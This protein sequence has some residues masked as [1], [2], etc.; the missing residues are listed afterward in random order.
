[1]SAISLKQRLNPAWLLWP[2]CLWL[3]IFIILPLCILIV[4]SFSKRGTYGELELAF[5]FGNYAKLLQPVYLRIGIRSLYIA[6]LS[7]LLCLI[8]A[9]PISLIVAFSKPRIQK[10]LLIA[11][12][13]PMWTNLLIRCYAWVYLLRSEGLLNSGLQMLGFIREPLPLIYNSFA[14]ILGLLYNFLP[15]AILPMYASIEKIDRRLFEAARDLGAGNWI[16]FKKI[17][18][19]LSL[20]G[21]SAAVLLVFVPSMSLYIIPDILGGGKTMLLGNLIQNQF[22]SARDWG[23]GS[24]LSVVILLLILVIWLLAM[25]V[26]G[27]KKLEELFS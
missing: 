7:T 3:G 1:M 5:Q 13:L 24:A 16:I 15:F 17:L 19:P 2:L 25:K 21:I 18:L 4:Y 6:G 11:L 27:R 12:V 14:V 9:F 22:L 8:L 23:A 20:P 10:I 26:T